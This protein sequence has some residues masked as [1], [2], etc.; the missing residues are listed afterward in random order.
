MELIVTIPYG[1]DMYRK[2]DLETRLAGA[3]PHQL[4]SLLF[5][6]A[7]NAISRA[8]IYFAKG[9]IARRG[10]MLSK[11]ISIIDNGLRASLNHE[12]A[13]EISTDLERLY[14]YM[15]YMLLVSNIKNDPKILDEVEALLMTLSQ[16]WQEI[17]P[18]MRSRHV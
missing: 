3:T 2:S 1:I 17:E 6:G 10:E 9:N 16:T 7:A 8:K 4:I 5:G 12:I 13:P 18:D 14:E 11:A 15:S